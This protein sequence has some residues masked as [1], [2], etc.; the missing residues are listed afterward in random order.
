MFHLE[1]SEEY[2]LL[3]SLFPKYRLHDR[4]HMILHSLDGLYVPFG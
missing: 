2:K 4:L 1:I 3:A